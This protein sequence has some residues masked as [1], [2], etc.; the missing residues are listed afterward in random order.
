[1]SNITGGRP[2]PEAAE[3]GLNDRDW[4]WFWWLNLAIT[5][6]FAVAMFSAR[7]SLGMAGRA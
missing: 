1:M 4:L 7:R 6:A 3:S 5:A 2:I